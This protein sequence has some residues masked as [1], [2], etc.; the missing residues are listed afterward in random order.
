MDGHPIAAAAARRWTSDLL[1]LGFCMC[2]WWA[3][4][5]YVQ[6]MSSWVRLPV[7]A[8]EYAPGPVFPRTTF[9]LVMELRGLHFGAVVIVGVFAFFPLRTRLVR[10]LALCAALVVDL[11]V[12]W[13]GG[14]SATCGEHAAANP[15]WAID[16][17]LAPAEDVRP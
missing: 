8:D 10:T 1:R 7:A 12:Y 6:G 5:D 16:C 2:A 13:G 9:D 15:Q 14:Y 4:V 17:E 11:L 3:I